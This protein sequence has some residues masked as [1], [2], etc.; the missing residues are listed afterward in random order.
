MPVYFKGDKIT[1]I[2]KDTSLFKKL[3]DRSITEITAE[4]LQGINRL[5]NFVFWGCYD[6]MSITIPDS[7]IRIDSYVC[8]ACAKLTSIIIPNSVTYVGYHSFYGCNGLTSV[9]IGNGLTHID[10]EVFY[11]CT[12]LT[13]ITINATTPPTL[14]NANAFG[15]T[16][17]CP[18]YVPAESVEA[19]KAATN[20]STLA[21]RIFAIPQ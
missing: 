13:S 20:W 16:N 9:V 7:V 10:G 11:N 17:N 1:P 8:Q 21:D 15:N 6:L 4:D 14:S 18:I 2:V 5:G 3:A 12:S 19:Y